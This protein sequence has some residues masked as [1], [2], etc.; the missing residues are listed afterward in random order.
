MRPLCE[1]GEYLCD[2]DS[3]VRTYIHYFITIQVMIEILQKR[4]KAV[5]FYLV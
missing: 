3:C 4:G 5:V 1:L 2:T